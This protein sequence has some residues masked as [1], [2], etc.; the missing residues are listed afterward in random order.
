M[1]TPDP[2]T[3]PT[4][5]DP[6]GPC[7]RCGRVSSFSQAGSLPTRT[8][9]HAVL[10]DHVPIERAVML[11]CQGC[12]EGSLVIEARDGVDAQFVPL[13]WWPTPG[14]RALDPAIPAAIGAAVSEGAR[15]LSVLA[16]HAGV[17][18]LRTAL[19]LIVKDKGSEAASNKNTLHAAIK[20]MVDD[21]ALWE[22]FGDWA[23]HIRQLGNAGAH[24][25]AFGP[26]SMD[27]ANDL[28]A[29]VQQLLEFLYVQ[30]ERVARARA[31]RTAVASPPE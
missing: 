29:L 24:Q 14:T 10:G 27:E 25:E 13:L 15:C 26:V 5:A 4:S 19:A 16:P 7:P 9:F 22:S 11:V 1:S 30:P 18:M 3:L 20:Q 28:F 31:Q 12:R 2:D 6:T 21:G 8:A 17:A 23:T